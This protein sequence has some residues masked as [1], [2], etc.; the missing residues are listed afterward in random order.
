LTASPRFSLASVVLDCPD[1]HTL[2]GFYSKLLGWDIGVDEPDWVILRNPTGSACLSF[3][4]ESWYRPPVWPE[5]PGE[6]TK[7]LHLD[8][9]VDDLDA[10]VAHALECGAALAPYQP[11]DNVRVL[12]DPAGHPFCLFID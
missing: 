1:A 5:Q 7:M 8:I 11:Q 9:Q 4:S 12:L 6:Q 3:Q 2:A 10:G